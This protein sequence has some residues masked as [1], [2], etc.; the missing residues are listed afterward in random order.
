MKTPAL[1]WRLRRIGR[2]LWSTV[3]ARKG[4]GWLAAAA[5]AIRRPVAG[6]RPGNAAHWLAALRQRTA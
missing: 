5:T 1:T 6:V 3:S 2:S 4:G